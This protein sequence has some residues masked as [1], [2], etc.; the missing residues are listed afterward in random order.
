MLQKFPLKEREPATSITQE[1]ALCSELVAV[2]FFL[3]FTLG[4]LNADFLVVLLQ[5]SKIFSCFRELSLF[6]SLANIPMN[7]CTLGVHEIE[8]VVD[9]REHFSDGSGVADHAHGTHDLGKI[10]SGHNS[11]WLVVN[12]T[13][14][15]CW[16]PINKL[17][18]TFGL[19]SCHGCIHILGDHI[20]TVH[21]AASHVLTMAWVAFS[22][23]GRWLKAGVC[24][25]S[26]G[27]L[28]MVRFLGRD[29]WSVTGQD[30][31][32]TWVWHQV[33]LELSNVNI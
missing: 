2:A 31:V 17:N 12:A 28:L 10:T 14:E 15:A 23:H 16:G 6:H 24:N 4:G 20:T 8:L 22:H 33:G 25:L 7:E 11:R 26:H 1:R 5:S 27:Q 18:G 30:E 29:D 32:N 21:H 13:L 9:A 3:T 19:D